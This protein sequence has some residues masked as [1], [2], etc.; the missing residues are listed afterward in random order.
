MYHS[1]LNSH[2]FYRSIAIIIGCSLP[3][4][5]VDAIRPYEKPTAAKEPVSRTVDVRQAISQ[6]SEPDKRAFID[7][8]HHVDRT[9]R[10][11]RLGESDYRVIGNQGRVIMQFRKE[12]PFY[13]VFSKFPASTLAVSLH[14]VSPETGGYAIDT[15]KKYDLFLSKGENTIIYIKDGLINDRNGIYA[16]L[17]RLRAKL[18][19]TAI[20][21]PFPFSA[22]GYFTFGSFG[23]DLHKA[24]K[25]YSPSSVYS[26]PDRTEPDRPWVGTPYIQ[27]SSDYNHTSDLFSVSEAYKTLEDRQKK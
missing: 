9:R 18:M 26:S 8:A 12:I 25:A 13:S 7:I 27:P 15:F 1:F 4:A 10:I 5:N 24:I 11:L 17:Y 16:D 6:L 19:V 20:A 2:I 14:G 3:Y 21:T 23:L 22:A